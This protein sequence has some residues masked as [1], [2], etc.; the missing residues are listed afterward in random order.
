M[1]MMVKEISDGFGSLDGVIGKDDEERNRA[2]INS[3][4]VIGQQYDSASL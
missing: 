1:V 4:V 3:K 2:E